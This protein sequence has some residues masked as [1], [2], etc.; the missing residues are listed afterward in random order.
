M[1]Y[2]SYLPKV[3]VRTSTF[4]QNNVE[5]FIVARNIFRKCTLIEDIQESVLGFQQYNIANNERPDLIANELYGDPLYDWVILLCNN[6][7]NIYDDW[8]MS[9]DELQTYVKTKY[10][11]ATGVHH[12]ETNEITELDSDTI[13]M[14]S[15]IQVNE[16]WTYTRSDGTVVA[17]SNFPVSNYEY[18]KSVNDS[19][20]SIWL[21]KPQFVEDFVEEFEELMKYA[22]NE[23]I[24]EASGVK[25]TPN[26]IKEVFITQKDQY[27]TEYGLTPSLSFASSVELVNKT[28]TTTTTE[29]GATS[30][31]GA[32]T[33]RVST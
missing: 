21:L 10:R 12:Y 1:S 31:L 5:P 16:N 11:F 28:V 29:S 22:P 23:E 26:I 14:K 2:F 25:I 8:P 17:N 24:D 27:S 18:E 19:K 13:L 7:V 9:E 4:R 33:L 20:A 15:G 3:Q 32:A 6:I 30:F